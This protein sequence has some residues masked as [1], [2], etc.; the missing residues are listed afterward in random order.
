MRTLT[1]CQRHLLDG[2]QIAEFSH[3][4]GS[5]HGHIANWRARRGSQ[6]S[7]LGL[8]QDGPERA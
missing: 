3:E 6:G 5:L 2:R 1:D 7:I 4:R 8:L